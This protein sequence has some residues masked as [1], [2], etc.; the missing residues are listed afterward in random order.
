[1]TDWQ[2]K[3]LDE[4][5][6]IRHGRNQHEVEDPAGKYPILGTGGEIGRTNSFL[7]DRP[8]VLIG[9]KGTIDKPRYM[10]TP[11]WTVD[12]LFYSSIH[13]N[14]VPKFMFYVFNTINW[15]EYNEASG[16]P[17]LSASTVSSIKI[18]LPEKLEQQRIVAVLEVWDEYLELLDQKI[19]LKEQ[20]KKGLMQQLL[21]SKKRLPGFTDEWK[22]VTLG[23]VADVHMGQSPSSSSYNEVGN[24]A[25]LI[26]GNADMKNQKTISRI[27]TTEITKRA[28]KGSLI[29]T[30]R[31]PAGE[32]AIASTDVCLGRGVCSVGSDRAD[33]L[34]HF[35]IH[36]KSQWR[37]YIQGSTFESIN[38]SDIRELPISIPSKLESEAISNLLDLVD[39][40]LATLTFKKKETT[41][42]KKYLLKNLIS[43][44]IRTPDS[45]G[46]GV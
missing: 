33:Y 36:F 30:V 45:T 32:I 2:S 24:G 11:F 17:S 35:L 10:N 16:V 9:R 6:T 15:Y 29:M 46:V 37:K 39:S 20:L 40:Q 12:T 25:V 4:C 19:A 26:Q 43:G 34:K 31:A 1:M 28:S 8:S 23:D 3:R 13:D 21:T 5:L 7:Y 41:K 18:N 27:W 14:A 44:T 38:G 42:Q 22:C